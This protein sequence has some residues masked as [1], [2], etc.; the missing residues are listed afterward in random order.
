MPV[1]LT[2]AVPDDVPVV[3]ELVR[4]LAAYEKLGHQVVA[5]EQDLHRWL[6]ERPIIECVLAREN[7]AAVGFALFFPSFSTFLGRPGIYL[8]DLFVREAARGRGVGRALVAYL[9][10]LTVE[11]GWGRLEWSVLDWNAPAI[12][13][14]RRL[15][16][17]VLDDWRVCRLTGDAL[18]NLASAHGTT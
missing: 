7:S 10:R 15:G 3:L 17:Q 8:E 1:T 9:A 5:T 13:F 12:G 6:F 16:A 11:R 14:Y 18:E 4:E 2:A